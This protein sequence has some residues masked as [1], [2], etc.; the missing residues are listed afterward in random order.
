MQITKAIQMIERAAQE[1]F[2]GAPIHLFSCK[3][4]CTAISTLKVE[5]VAACI[6]FTE[7][8]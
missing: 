8:V 2:N 1:H 5:Y 7:M 6:T 3:Q 4:T